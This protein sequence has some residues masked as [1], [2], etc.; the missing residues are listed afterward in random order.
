MEQINIKILLILSLVLIV[1]EL[2]RL[3]NVDVWNVNV[4]NVNVWNVDEK[5]V[6]THIETPI[7]NYY[8]TNFPQP[9]LGVYN[10][11]I[12]TFNP[13]HTHTFDPNKFKSHHIL[14]NGYKKIKEE[15]LNVYNKQITMNMNDLGKNG[16]FSTIDSEKGQWKV[17]VLKWYDKVTTSAQNQCP[18]TVKLIEQCEDLHIAMFSILEP[19]KYIPKHKGPSTGCL[20]YHIGLSIPKD[21]N[22]CYIEVNNE[23]FYWQEGEGLVFDDTYVHSVH[24]NTDEPRIILFVD[25][26]RPLGQIL[27]SINHML[28][29]NSSFINFNKHIN[30]AA[31]KAQNVEKF[32]L[33]NNTNDTNDTAPYV[34]NFD[35]M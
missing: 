29:N 1:T 14:K 27:G 11:I 13:S 34:I 6:K 28:T 9:F 22:N 8:I 35:D 21:T 19:K 16:E 24:N 10:S 31:E 20:R 7:E 26:E 12:R 33:V 30:D 23:K 3:W 32:S 17:F 5:N 25:L 18:E 2:D 15:A 4:W